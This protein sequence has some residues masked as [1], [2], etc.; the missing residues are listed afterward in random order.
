MQIQT[1]V[2]FD[3]EQVMRIRLEIERPEGSLFDREFIYKE[4]ATKAA[5]S[6][7]VNDFRNRLAELDEYKFT[8]RC[9][10]TAASL[11]HGH[12][13]VTGEWNKAEDADLIAMIFKL[14]ASNLIRSV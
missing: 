5:I 9:K 7:A 13:V 11:P 3:D 2:S 10:I 4:S 8:Y 6:A 1:S 12:Q 14:G